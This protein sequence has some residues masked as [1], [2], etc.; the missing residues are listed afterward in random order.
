MDININFADWCWV[1]GVISLVVFLP[2]TIGGIG[3]REGS[4]VILLGQLSVSSEKALAL[5]LSIFGLQ[6]I[7]GLTG[8][9]IDFMINFSKSRSRFN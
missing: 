5:S 6:I 9:I 8:G 4:F 1:F 2:I 7:G 3:L